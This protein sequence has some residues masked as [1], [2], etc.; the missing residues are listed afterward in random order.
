MPHSFPDGFSPM[1]IEVLIIG[2]D[3]DVFAE[4]LGTEFSELRFHP[5]HDAA[6][7]L[8]ACG[9]C[10]ILLVRNDEIFADLIAAMPRLRF[11]QALTTGTDDIAALP[12]LPPQVLVAAARGF[13]GP[14]MSE[15]AFLFML[16]FARKFPAVLEKQRRRVWDRCEQRLLAG[17]TVV[18]VGVGGIAE[19]L[20]RR[21]KVFGMTVI[22]VSSRTSAP[23]FDALYPRARLPE[24]ASRADFLIVLAPLTKENRHLVDAAAIDAMKSEGV[25]INI[26]RGGVV[27]EDALLKALVAKRIAGAGLDV[28]QKEPLPS[29]SPFWDMPNVIITS[30]VGGMS[31]EYADQVMPL[32]VDNL[33]AFV[34]GKPERISHIVK[35]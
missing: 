12:N 34:D 26:A 25:L 32:L 18:I 2:R 16:A 4:R 5:A 10:E 11:I 33:R 13:H 19:E 14:Q 35:V 3:S 1:T 15:L 23:G 29:D 27:D 20:A 28:F 22:G 6:E 31:E 24:A 7:A 8:K 30:H 17:K 9:N 21:C